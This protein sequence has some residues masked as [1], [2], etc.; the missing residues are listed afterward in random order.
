MATLDQE[1]DAF[2]SRFNRHFKKKYNIYFVFIP[3]LL[4]ILSI[5]GY[6]VFMIVYKW[7][8][9]SVENSRSA[10]SILIQFINMFMFSGKT[11]NFLFS[12]QVCDRL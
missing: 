8:A 11:D 10:P 5:F 3:Q 4:F 6:L 1:S 7:L 9:F 12:G 2:L